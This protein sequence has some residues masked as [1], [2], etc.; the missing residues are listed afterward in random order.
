MSKSR[1]PKE[2]QRYYVVEN[3]DGSGKCLVEANSQTQ[4]L[5]YCA[6]HF[7]TARVATVRE[8][9]NMEREGFPVIRWNK[10]PQQLDIEEVLPP[11]P[12]APELMGQI[13]RLHEDMEKISGVATAVAPPP[14]A[15]TAVE[16]ANATPP[17]APRKR[18]AP[19]PQRQMAADVF[20]KGFAKADE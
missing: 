17:A 18:V 12:P 10:Q 19:A 15:E 7:A 1:V 16:K 9:V 3:K 20:G 6:Q 4:A 11:Q 13:Q 5:S 14:P 2:P 8:A